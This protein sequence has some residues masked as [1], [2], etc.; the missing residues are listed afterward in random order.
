LQISDGNGFS[1]DLPVSLSVSANQLANLKIRP[2]TV[3]EDIL[4]RVGDTYQFEVVG[5]DVNGLDVDIGGQTVAWTGA[6]VI[7][8]V[9]ASGLFSA[10]T[11]GIGRLQAS[12]SVGGV[13][14]VGQSAQIEVIQKILGDS[15]GTTASVDYPDGQPDGKV[16]IFDLVN[17]ASHWHQTE[18]DT[19]ASVREFKDL[20]IAG[21]NAAGD[22]TGFDQ[23]DQKIDIFDL[24][25]LVD[26]YGTG[27]TPALAAPAILAT[28]PLFEGGNS[29]LRVV[30]TDST[31]QAG[32]RVRTLL[33]QQIELDVLLNQLPDL[34]A[35]SFDLVYDQQ[36]LDLVTQEDGQPVFQDGSIL[37]TETEATHSIVSHKTADDGSQLASANVTATRLGHQPVDQQSGA[38]A[39]LQLLAKTVGQTQL[40]VKNLI[41]VTDG[42]ETYTLA[43]RTYDLTVHLPV[44]QSQLDQNYPNPFNPETWIPFQLKSASPVVISIYDTTGKMVRE[45]DVGYRVAGPHHSRQEAAYWDGRN[46]WG[47]PVSSGVYFY[48]LKTNDSVSIKKMTVL[49]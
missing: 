29:D 30:D 37:G 17:M 24:I 34:Y 38:L 35:Y 16:D 47:E 20:D 32:D 14:V 41:L 33:D 39:R 44:E 46:R 23:V 43:D 1:F 26:N 7:G 19:T 2:R 48:H 15:T 21:K 9:D 11:V 31:S 18:D 10:T 13:V 25:V 36:R 45:L 6:S 42:G 5:L 4:L 12:A 3:G 8:T 40:Q 28:L 22:G 27:L 49:K